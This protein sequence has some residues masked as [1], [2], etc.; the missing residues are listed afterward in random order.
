VRRLLVRASAVPSST[1]LVT[2]MKEELSCSET[3][4]LKRATRRNIPKDT[5]LHS[6]RREEPQILPC[7]PKIFPF[8]H[9]RKKEREM[10]S[11]SMYESV[12]LFSERSKIFLYRYYHNYHE[13]PNKKAFHLTIDICSHNFVSHW[14][15]IYFSGTIF[16]STGLCICEGRILI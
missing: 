3:S 4:V 13:A 10:K 9:T 7:V 1:I 2:L 5:L 14:F 6:H 8:L 12:L 16:L 15:L 11:Q